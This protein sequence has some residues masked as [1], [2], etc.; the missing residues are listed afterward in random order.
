MTGL[1]DD[2]EVPEPVPE[3]LNICSRPSQRDHVDQIDPDPEPCPRMQR[4]L[5]TCA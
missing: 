2:A 1:T 4:N 3:S 5:P